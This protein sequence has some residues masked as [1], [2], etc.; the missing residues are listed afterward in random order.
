MRKTLTFTGAAISGLHGAFQ[1]QNSS[2]LDANISAL[3]ERDSSYA[4][5]L[6]APLNVNMENM[7]AGHR[8]HSSHSSHRSHSSHYS[9]S[10][11]SYSPP[12]APRSTYTPPPAPRPTYTPPSS[13]RPSAAPEPSTYQS[14]TPKSSGA[15]SKPWRDYGTQQ[16]LEPSRSSRPTV[17]QLQLMI[18]RVQAAL[19]SKGYDPGA[20][21]GVLGS[22]TKSALRSFQTDHGLISSGAMTTETLNALGVSLRP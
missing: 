18:M 7:Y 21:D 8:S 2:V 19:Y 6:S 20:I 5:T 9:G 17:D 14:V 12:P 1:D 13:Y 11:S 22:T 15:T 4:V 3:A 16:V 10:G